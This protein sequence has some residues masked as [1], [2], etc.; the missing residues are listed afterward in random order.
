MLFRKFARV[1][2]PPGTRAGVIISLLAVLLSACNI[3]STPA[4]TVDVNAI[5]TSAAETAIAAFNAQLTQTAAA[6]SPTPL[7]TNTSLPTNTPF[8][9]LAVST[10]LGGGTPLVIASPIGTL[11][12]PQCN[13][14]VFIADVTIPDGSEM[15]PGQDFEKVWSIQNSGT[16]R[17][18][19]GYSFVAVSGDTGAMDGYNVLIELEKDFIDPGET[20][21]FQIDLTAPLAEREYVGCW[22]MKDD[23]GFFFGTFACVTIVVNAH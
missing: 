17:W 3:G 22:R 19:E 23:G 5:Y 12:G 21:N 8:A 11:S 2:I 18:D 6:A 20:V 7:P 15:D 16:C 9:T 14:A 4:P 10:P 1:M 13:D